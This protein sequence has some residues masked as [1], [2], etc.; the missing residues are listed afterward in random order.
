MLD[1]KLLRNDLDAVAGNLARRGFVLDCQRFRALE[2]E[3]KRLQHEVEM[4]RQQRNTRSKA[5][6]AARAAGEDIGALRKE[7]GALGDALAKA[8][9]CQQS[10]IGELGEL[11][12]GLPN[13]LSADVPDGT[14]ETANVEIR[15]WGEPPELR[16][17]PRDHADLGVALG[18][19]DLDAATK[20]AG[21]RFVV[22]HGA[23]ARLH[24]A[25]IQFMLDV[26]TQEH[27]YAET[28]VPYLVNEHA[29]FGTGQLPKFEEDLFA[30]AGD[31]RYFLIPTA[32]VPLTNLVRESIVEADRLPIKLAA[33]TP[34]FRSEAG[35]YG[36]DTRGMFRQHQFEKVE[37][38]HIVRPEDSWAALEELVG[39]AEV[40]LKRLGLAYR[41]VTL[42]AGDTGASAA[43]TYDIE[44]WLPGQQRYREISSCS[45][46]EAFQA[47]RMRARW[48][49]P[50]TGRPEPLHT[51]NGSG[52]A[53]GRALIAV[54]ETYQQA[55][56]SIAIP[57]ALK[58][59]MG[60]RT[61]IE[62]AA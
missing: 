38:V 17:E 9:A 29:L 10:V 2:S 20:L 13:L 18:M 6:G 45:N 33:H 25:L 54:L 61:L 16:F 41:V 23:L 22:L 4:L 57:D 35:S 55:D 15:R 7:V 40:I 26:H 27:G 1:P 46:F 39:N 34:C 44:V 56:G 53:A 49:N 28:Y 8:E 31:R 24:R 58:P 37:L 42:C 52:V 51:L 50:D 32:E 11:T 59:Y 21:S 30:V 47:R 36:K 43:K 14:D 3:R 62:R 5:I 60:G 19:L 12:Q 48:R